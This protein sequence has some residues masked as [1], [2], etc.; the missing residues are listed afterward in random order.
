MS[1]ISDAFL[2]KARESLAGANSELINGRYN[3][4]ANR[5]YDSCFQAAV[6]ALDRA[7]IRPVSTQEVW[8][9]RFVQ[10]QFSARIRRRKAFPAEHRATLSQLLSPR[11]QADYKLHGVT[12]PQASR[13]LSRAQAF[14][15]AVIA[16]EAGTA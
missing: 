13:A 8:S 15:T 12:K 5:C 3:N 14:A 16:E 10:A 2:V 1:D 6:V 7:G 11:E 4:V 9:H